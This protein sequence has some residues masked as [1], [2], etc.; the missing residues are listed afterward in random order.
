[1]GI[2]R[3][4]AILIIIV[5]ALKIYFGLPRALRFIHAPKKKISFY[6]ILLILC[7]EILYIGYYFSLKQIKGVLQASL[8][9]GSVVGILGSL[10]Y[11]WAY[12]RKE[13]KAKLFIYMEYE[14]R[15]LRYKLTY[16]DYLKSCLGFF[17]I[18]NASHIFLKDFSN[19]LVGLFY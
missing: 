11:S 1:M 14:G 2:V 10:L 6:F 19:V 4:L 18:F 7:I 13:K 17:V 5:G 12:R 9:F 16:K 3:L 8:I 15:R